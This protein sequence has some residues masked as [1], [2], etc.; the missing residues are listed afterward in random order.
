MR[1][2]VCYATVPGKGHLLIM[3]ELVHASIHDGA[4]ASK[5]E[6]QFFKHNDLTHLEQLLGCRKLHTKV[7]CC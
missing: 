3:D 7:C 6:K 5:A 2:M 4:R 1:I